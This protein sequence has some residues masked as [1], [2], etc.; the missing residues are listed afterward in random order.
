[1]V[2]QLLDTRRELVDSLISCGTDIRREERVIIDLAEPLTQ[3]LN[4]IRAWKLVEI[5]VP[6]VVVAE[7]PH[8]RLLGRRV[9]DSGSEIEEGQLLLAILDDLEQGDGGHASPPSAEPR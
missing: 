1:M 9:R 4:H 6:L 3:C 2:A 5:I 7:H 8:H